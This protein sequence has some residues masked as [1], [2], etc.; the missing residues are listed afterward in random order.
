MEFDA[1]ED[2]LKVLDKVRGINKIG[3]K[4]AG[5]LY[6]QINVKLV[7]ALEKTKKGMQS[8]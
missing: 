3:P 4:A 6:D 2:A 1:L 5:Y 7:P 8:K